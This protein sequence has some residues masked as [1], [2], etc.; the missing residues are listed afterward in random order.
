VLKSLSNAAI[1]SPPLRTPRDVA[2]NWIDD[3]DIQAWKVATGRFT[4][5][6]KGTNGEGGDVVLSSCSSSLLLGKLWIAAIGRPFGRLS[7]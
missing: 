1:S 7:S 4:R 2:A 5:L 3:C 6:A